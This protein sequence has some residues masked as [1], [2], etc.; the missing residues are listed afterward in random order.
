MVKKKKHDNPVILNAKPMFLAAASQ[1]QESSSRPQPSLIIK[2]LRLPPTTT[3]G[4]R[5]A[6]RRTTSGQTD[7]PTPY[8]A[9][10]EHG[11]V[12]KH[13]GDDEEAHVGAS[14]IDLVEVGDAAVASGDGDVLELDVHVVLGC[15]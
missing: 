5:T 11:R 4:T 3:A 6:D 8:V 10:A 14:D 2:A 13:V 7:T 12:A 15:N 9:A 1:A